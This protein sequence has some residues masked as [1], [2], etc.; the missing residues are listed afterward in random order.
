[1]RIPCCTTS[2]LPCSVRLGSLSPP[3][4]TLSVKSCTKTLCFDQN[5]HIQTSSPS[6]P[7][8]HCSSPIFH[9]TFIALPPKTFAF[10]DTISSILKKDARKILPCFCC[11]SLRIHGCFFIPVR[12]SFFTSI[13][14]KVYNLHSFIPEFK[15]LFSFEFNVGPLGCQ[16]WELRA[17]RHAFREG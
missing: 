11:V 14:W 2:R 15:H 6:H 10:L 12:Y 7:N 13:F 1:M 16:I 8:S 3:A 17:Y 5:S 4:S 9:P